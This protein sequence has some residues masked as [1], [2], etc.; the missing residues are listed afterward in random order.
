MLRRQFGGAR[1]LLVEDN[2]VNQEVMRELLRSVGLQVELAG[3]GLEAIAR[4]G[5][6]P[7]ALVLMDDADAAH[8]RPGG[9]AAPG[10]SWTVTPRCRSSR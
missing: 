8:G 3:D 1:V 9:D 6:A 4:A 7:Y 5:A 2:E 10:A